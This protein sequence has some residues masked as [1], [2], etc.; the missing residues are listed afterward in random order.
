MKSTVLAILVLAP[1]CAQQPS[2]VVVAPGTPAVKAPQEAPSAA[3]A[4]IKPDT[5]VMETANGKKYTA[6][7]VDHLIQLLPAQYQ[8]PA[9]SQ[10]QAAAQLLTQILFFQRL[11]EEATKDELD[12]RSP[13]KEQMELARTQILANAEVMIHKNSIIVKEEDREKYYKEH[14]D[15]FQEAKV[16]VILV[17]FNPNPGKAVPGS[18]ALRS[19]AEAKAKMDD[20]RKQIVGGADFGKLA[21]ENSDDVGSAGKD[22]DF[23]A[24]KRNSPYPEPIKNAVFALKPGEMSEPIRQPTGFW[25]L[26]LEDLQTQPYGEVGDQITTEIQQEEFQNWQKAIQSQYTVKVDNPAYFAPKPAPAQLQQIR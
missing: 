3:A 11:A 4:E 9:R 15:R 24:M 21:R 22:G 16:R 6:A 18:K 19:E 12:K 13:Y 5:I 1:L 17:S 26:R 23:G 2:P 20:L 25:L 7:E 8:G 14:P 10:P